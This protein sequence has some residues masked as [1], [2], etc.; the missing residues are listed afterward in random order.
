MSAERR[1]EEAAHDVLRDA[2]RTASLAQ[3]DRQIADGGY[4]SESLTETRPE[5]AGGVLVDYVVMA[6]F[7]SGAGAHT[8]ASVL[9]TDGLCS[10]HRTVGLLKQAL[11][12]VLA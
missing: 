1:A 11:H 4:D 10:K 5:V 7:D 9:R 3:W 6:V 8:V 2:I 12:D